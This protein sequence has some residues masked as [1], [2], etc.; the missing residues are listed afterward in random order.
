MDRAIVI[1]WVC[2]LMSIL[3]MCARIFLGRWCKRKFDVGD[4]LT[5]TAIF[6]AFALIAFAHTVVLWKN[7]DISPSLGDIHKLSTDE[8]R[9]REIGSKF[10]LVVR[11]LYTSL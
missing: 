1:V 6:F 9:H 7:N 4:A 2:G 8:I 11:C 5:T 3:I 10:T